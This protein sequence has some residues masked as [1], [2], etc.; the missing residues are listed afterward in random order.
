M[1]RLIV[2]RHRRSH[3]R[4]QARRPRQS[5]HSRHRLILWLKM[6]TKLRALFFFRLRFNE[7]MKKT[8]KHRPPFFLIKK[9]PLAPKI[10]AHLHEK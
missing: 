7:K 9:N 10:E 2:R 1:S 8:N 6:R 5:G 4:R 3:R